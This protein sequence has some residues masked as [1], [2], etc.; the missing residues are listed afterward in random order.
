[1]RTSKNLKRLLRFLKGLAATLFALVAAL[2]IGI[3]GLK[4]W[5]DSEAFSG[6]DPALPLDAAVLDRSEAPGGRTETVEIT[7]REGERFPYRLLV[8]SGAEP[9]YPCVVL[10]Y[11]IGQRMAFFDEIAPL[12]A[13]RGVVLAVPEQYDRGVRRVG[14]GERGRA[15]QAIGKAGRFY[16]RCSRIVP[17]TRRLVDDLLARGDIDPERLDFL[18]ASYGGI[19]GCA[20]MRYEPRFR[21]GVLSLAGG[22]LGALAGN[23]VESEGLGGGAKALAAVGSWWLSPFEPVRHVGEISPRPLLFLNLEADEIIPRRCTEALFAAAAEP[24]EIEWIDASHVVIDE[25][26][27]RGLISRSLDWL[28]RL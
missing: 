13:D 19:L 26:L 4:R 20:A 22:D 10:L 28:E 16:G 6:Y 27:V 2:S 12:F 1:M 8:P 9:P 25:A 23:L 11:G 21:A 18:G 17:E 3:L 5:S 24:K 15:G 14:A 7:G